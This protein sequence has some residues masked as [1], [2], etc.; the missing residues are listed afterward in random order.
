VEDEH[1]KCDLLAS[2]RGPPPGIETR[3]PG[4]KMRANEYE[5]GEM[6]MDALVRYKERR[7]FK[8]RLSKLISSLFASFCNVQALV[9]LSLP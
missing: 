1:G 7:D 5:G 9:L 4:V 2:N 3:G 6:P 8:V